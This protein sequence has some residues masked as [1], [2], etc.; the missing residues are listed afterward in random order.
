MKIVPLLPLGNQTLTIK[1][2]GRVD[3]HIENLMERDVSGNLFNF[4]F[5]VTG[6]VNTINVLWQAVSGS[7][8]L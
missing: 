2:D 1:Y 7:D 8:R 6:D 4:Q 3:F 5:L